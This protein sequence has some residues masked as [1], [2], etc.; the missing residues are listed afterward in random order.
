MS[1]VN[2]SS[3]RGPVVGEQT[4]RMYLG[5]LGDALEQ[6]DARRRVAW[7]VSQARGPRVLHVGCGQ[8]IVAILLGRKHFEV[9]GID[10]CR[11]A[12]DLARSLLE[13]EDPAV[14]RRVRFEL[15]D[16]SLDDLKERDFETVILGEGIWSHRDSKLLVDQGLSRLRKAGRCVM[17]TRLA[18]RTLDDHVHGLG[19]RGV[20]DLVPDSASEFDFKLVGDHALLAFVRGREG[21]GSR[22]GAGALFDLA[23]SGFIEEQR[24][25]RDQLRSARRDVERLQR[26]AEELG[27][28]ASRA[29]RDALAEVDGH[30]V[31]G[32]YLRLLGDPA[33]QSALHFALALRQPIRHLKKLPKRLFRNIFPGRER[34]DFSQ[35]TGLLRNLA[36]ET[37]HGEFPRFHPLKTRFLRTATVATILDEFSDQCLRYEWNL[38]RLDPDS[39]KDQLAAGNVDL[40]FVESAW[41]GND[42]AWKKTI[43]QW[44]RTDN[45]LRDVVAYC[46]SRGIPTVF[47]SKE[48]PPHFDTFKQT[49]RH[50]DHIFTTDQNCVPKYKQLCGHESVFALPFAAQPVLHNPAMRSLAP[51]RDVAFAGEWYAQR[52]AARRDRLAPLLSSVQKSRYQLTIFD[53]FSDLKGEVALKHRFPGEYAK[54]IR[55]KLPYDQ[56]LSAY[57]QFPVFLNVNSVADSPTM[58]SRRVFELLACGTHVISSPS[59]GM[60][61]MLA[62]CVS[63]ASV[64]SESETAV[65]ELMK[66]SWQN[67]VRAHVAYR[68][69]MTEHTYRHR[70]NELLRRIGREDLAK[71]DEP[72]VS[73]IL[74]TNR[75][76]RLSAAIESYRRQQ[77]DRKELILVLNSDAFELA[78]VERAM[79][80]VPRASVIQIPESHTLAACLNRALHIIHGSYWA[81]MD[82]DDFYGVHYLS[83]SLLP[84]AYTDASIV[85]KWGYLLRFT[86]DDGLYLR[87]AHAVH[88]YSHLV[89]GGT[90]VVKRSV[91]ERVQFDE[92]LPRGV[93]T[94]FLRDAAEAG[95]LIYS[96]DPFNFVQ[97]RDPGGHGHTWTRDRAEILRNCRRI[98]EEFRE[99]DV[100]V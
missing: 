7:M 16:S 25:L 31:V 71:T 66:P 38:V 86:D 67:R 28:Q 49:A 52:H 6:E 97:L 44:T 40:L 18:S 13:R 90:L 79:E 4:G 36:G 41:R 17:T 54:A 33:V 99:R 1:P 37:S 72:L 55:A 27:A 29:D 32:E 60:E 5:E 81:K 19:V 8:G 45:P 87:R 64:E 3:Q 73:V 62:G 48:D 43:N 89:C 75:P 42:R 63:V 24:L 22:P 34:R 53:G 12:I 92:S 15:C 88:R 100:D 21:E 20:I 46:K 68:R 65:K 9:L 57:R 84:F 83:D 95:F 11:N 56:I 94:A 91:H 35:L 76:E 2:Q 93:D 10:F 47:W 98:F 80:N 82:D 58:F 26:S 85:G 39:W 78:E 70:C 23:A 74:V 61:Q 51:G 50:F 59:L 77:Y 96:S 14:G 30:P 69:V